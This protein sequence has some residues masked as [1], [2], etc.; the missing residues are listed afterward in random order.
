VLHRIPLVY[1]KYIPVRQII[2]DN[3]HPRHHLDFPHFNSL[4]R[5]F[6]KPNLRD[7]VIQYRVYPVHYCM[8]NFCSLPRSWHDDQVIRAS[9]SPLS[10]FPA[11]RNS[12]HHGQQFMGSGTRLP[13]TVTLLGRS[14]FNSTLSPP[15][16]S[17]VARKSGT[18]RRWGVEVDSV[19][20]QN[21]RLNEIQEIISQDRLSPTSWY[22]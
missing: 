9:S 4:S 11:C 1:Q 8:H 6:L 12:H 5:P 15:D 18:G 22:Q 17:S 16:D 10:L 20:R 7:L 3:K 21:G 14:L 13:R 19:W 2:I